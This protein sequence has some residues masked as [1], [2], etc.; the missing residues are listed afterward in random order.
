MSE[1]KSEWPPRVGDH[2]QIVATGAPGM[3]MNSNGTGQF[4]VAIYSHALRSV[5]TAPYR[6]YS[7]R[8]IGPASIPPVVVDP[9]S[10][11]PQRRTKRAPAG[12]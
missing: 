1:S 5:T 7:I 2:V 11:T 6:T 9:V 8:Q 3:V 10:P 12:D 4:L